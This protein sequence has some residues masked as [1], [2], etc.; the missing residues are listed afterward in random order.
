MSDGRRRRVNQLFHAALEHE[1][2]TR[3]AFVEFACAEDTDLRRQVELLL[4]KQEEAGSCLETPAIA[5]TAVTQ[6]ATMNPPA[7]QFGAYRI[8]SPLGAGGMGEV[9]RAHDS[10]LGRD[11]A[12]K[13]L[14]AEFARDP[15]RLTRF[16]REA[17]TLASLN[18]PHIG[19]I[20]GLEEDGGMECLVLELVEGEAL[21]GPLPI[22]KAL[23]YARQV[24]EALEAAHAKGIIHRD[25]KPSNIKVTPEGQVKVLD[26]G[27]AKAIW[28]RDQNPAVSQATGPEMVTLTGHIVGTAGYMSPE[29]A[30]GSE[31]DV[32]TD[33]WAFGCLLYELLTGK[34]AFAGET[35]QDTM[36]AVREREPD[37]SALPPNTPPKIA[38]LLRRCVHKAPD[39]RPQSATEVRTIVDL[40]LRRGS[41]WRWAGV[42]AALAITAAG[43]FWTWRTFEQQRNAIHVPTITRLTTDSGLTAYPA[44]SRD[45]K[46][47]AYASDRATNGNLDIWTQQTAG[48]NPVRLTTNDADDLEPSFSPDGSRIVFRSERDGGG[49]YVVPALGGVERR[50]ADLGRSPRFSPNGK[51]IAYWV[52]DQSYYGH[53]QIFVI[54]ATGGQ[55]RGVQPA[56]FSASRPVWSPDGEHLLFRGARDAKEAEAGHFDWWVSPLDPGPAVQT[57]G[58]ELLRQSKLAAM[59]RSQLIGGFGVEPS[60]WTRDSIVFSASSGSAGLSGS[61]WRASIDSRYRIQRPVQRLTSGTENELQPSAADS[62]IAFASIT[63]NENIWSLRVDPNT[64]RV[65][66]EPL[67]ITNGTAADVLPSSSADGRKVAYASNRTGNLHIWMKDLETGTEVPLTSTPFNDLPWLLNA[68]GS[69]LIYCV[70][71]APDSSLDKG[72]FIRPT[73]GGVARRFCADCPV[74][75]I[76]DWFD[77]DRKILYK[78]GL[79]ADTEFD[80]HDI[81]SG[82]ETVLLRHPKYNVTAARFSPD[83][84]WMSFQVVIEAATRRQIFITPIRNGIAA[85]EPEWVPIT[86]GAGLDRNAVWSPDGNLLYFLSERDGFRCVWA[87][88]LSAVTKHPSGGPFAVYHFHQARRSLMPAQEVARIGLSVT[89]DKIVFSMAE[90]NGNIWLADFE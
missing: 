40:S 16:R 30:N 41:R 27:L 84:R 53:R 17:R 47:L 70:F 5:Y 48:G 62:N 68:D 59:E 49:V 50:V 89:R 23:E 51:W 43:S 81:N 6:T 22:A 79:T 46:L 71:G 44:L 28:G 21:R 78:K 56:F 77:H 10:K 86:D 19:A 13:F 63:Q 83:G 14:P 57:G 20:F 58:F 31:V 29:Q 60:E 61:L 2:E 66:G 37:W 36:A 35:L 67:R 39:R 4:A 52:G 11:V 85:P 12:V 72:C 25:L 55:P 69:L 45:G 9:F 64:G 82:R 75:S 88:R 42:S 38:A 74:S 87:Q 54:P 1:P 90:T 18:H 32:R 76:L 33:I 26:F 3:L 73:S 34:R 8:I 65:S 80:L 15:D 7:R 24:A